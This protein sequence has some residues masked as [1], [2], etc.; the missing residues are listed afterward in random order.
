MVCQ[1]LEPLGTDPAGLWIIKKIC[2]MAGSVSP[3][4]QDWYEKIARDG[5]DPFEIP[6]RVGYQTAYRGLGGIR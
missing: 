1:I 3:F 2:D 6:F 5:F 4:V